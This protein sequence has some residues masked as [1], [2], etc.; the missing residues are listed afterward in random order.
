[1]DKANEFA[2]DLQFSDRD[3]KTITRYLE[4]LS[5]YQSFLNG[6]DPS[7]QA[8]REFLGHLREK[9][10]KP[11]SVLLYYHA[12]RLFHKFI[13]EPVAIKLKKVK[14]RPRFHPK[15]EVDAILA[16]ID[17][18]RRW[19]KNHERDRLIIRILAECGLRRQELLNLRVLDI[20]LERRIMRVHGKGKKDR[21]IPIPRG[22]VEE[23]A[24][25]VRGKSPHEGLFPFKQAKNIWRIVTKYA[26]MAGLD[27]F[28]PHT[29]RHYYGSQL[30]DKQVDLKVIQ[31]LLGHE[32]IG[33]TAIYRDIT[34]KHLRDAV[35]KLDEESS[36][37]AQEIG[38]KLG[39]SPE[40]VK[41]I[42]E[43]LK[44]AK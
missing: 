37:T 14:D 31:E 22:L 26:R 4:C 7:E 36:P 1:M 6:K 35:D 19:V 21:D 30:A 40:L 3:P 12:L 11:R 38:Q 17:Q 9:G 23:L 16:A 27:D 41:A 5:K 10:Y 44:G 2:V 33:T 24:L 34:A 29:L 18:D 15:A 25:Y 43:L 32:D 20:D 42:A 28:H 8:L 39:V 13:G